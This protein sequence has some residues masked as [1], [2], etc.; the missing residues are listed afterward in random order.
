M[1]KK[2]EKDGGQK[3]KRRLRPGLTVEERKA[4]DG[5]TLHGAEEH[6]RVPDVTRHCG[7]EEP[8]DSHDESRRHGRAEQR[9]ETTVATAVGFDSGRKAMVQV[10]IR[11]F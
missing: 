8:W 11:G 5:T 1:N 10:G 2:I 3:W 7:A 6:T 4:G 9:L